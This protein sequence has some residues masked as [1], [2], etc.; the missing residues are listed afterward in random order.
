MARKT[1][2]DLIA[3]GKRERDR[4]EFCHDVIKAH[5]STA[6]YH[7][8]MEAEEYYAGRNITMRRYQKMLYNAMGQAI[9]DYFNANYK[10]THGFFRRFVTQQVQYVLS[11]GVTFEKK[12]TKKKLGKSFDY[13]LQRLAKKAM[14]DGVSFGF[15]NYDHLEVFSLVPTDSDVAFAPL[16]D[17]ETGALR[18]GVRYW[19]TED[20]TLRM[21]L[22]EEDGFT[23]YIMPK[24]EIIRLYAEK[25]AYII[26]TRT[27]PAFGVEVISYS[28]YPGFPIVPVYANDLHSTELNS[29]RAS[30]DCYD[31]IKS[32]MANNVDQA[33]AFYWTLTNCGGMDDIDLVNFVDK[34]NKVKAAV[35][36]P[37]IE[38]E[39]HTLSVPVDANEKLLDRLRT[40]MYEDFMLMD[41]EKAL[42][43]NMTATA[44]RLAYQ[45][46]D[47]KCGDF[48]Y[49]IREFIDHILQLA[50]IEDEPSFKWNRIANQSEET[51]MVM[52]AAAHLDDAA[53][54]KHLPW[55]TPEEVEETLERMEASAV[56]RTATPN[57][58]DAE[59]AP[60]EIDEGKEVE[61]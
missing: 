28:N 4:M 46:Q 29:I 25:T 30:I 20:G 58:E 13:A 17:K 3:V 39:A 2:Q 34:M 42:S 47:D 49:M 5:E 6:Q 18:A 11:N 1:Y 33:S 15:W 16:W 53:I 7:K 35:L 51:Q 38:A 8:A 9:P 27:T 44:I 56:E 45:P 61:E 41:T 48:E 40:D 59:D 36:M 22:Y 10:L 43:G 52:M 19:N 37:G 21:T 12:D 31:F 54:L 57:R 32:G 50:G 24:D 23:E 14:V 55:M 60:D 26:E